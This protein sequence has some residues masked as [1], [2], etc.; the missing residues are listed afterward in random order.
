MLLPLFNMGFK[1]YVLGN[2]IVMIL[3]PNSKPAKRMIAEAK[4][5]NTFIDLTKKRQVNVYC[6]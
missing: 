3:N 1:N 5:S 2:S 4:N 6:Y